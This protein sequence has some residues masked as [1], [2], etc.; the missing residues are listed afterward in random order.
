M[1]EFKIVISEKGKSYVKNLTSDESEVFL[2]K[3]IKD[4]IEG[5]H[6]GFKGYELEIRGGSDKEG[7]PMRDDVEGVGRKRIFITKGRVGAKIKKKGVRLRKSVSGNTVSQLTS[8]IN[9]KVIKTGQKPLDEIFGKTQK[10][11]SAEEKTESK[12]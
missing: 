8:Q 1:P 11:N 3:K 2:D 5:S 12:E 10:E 4:K 7:F 6:F 9:L